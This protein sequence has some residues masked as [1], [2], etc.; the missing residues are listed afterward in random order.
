MLW[1][2]KDLVAMEKEFLCLLK[3]LGFRVCIIEILLTNL[4]GVRRSY[5]LHY[6]L[7]QFLGILF[8]W[9][10]FLNRSFKKSA[11]VHI[12]RIK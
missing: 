6:L 8:E 10:L 11:K 9:G 3:L 1:P 4:R 5:S 7:W 12:N 2:Q